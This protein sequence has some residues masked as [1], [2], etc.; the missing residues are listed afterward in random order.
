MSLFDDLRELGETAEVHR[1]AG[2]VSSGGHHNPVFHGAETIDCI[3]RPWQSDVGTQADEGYTGQTPG[4]KVFVDPDL[5][6]GRGDRLVYR[7]GDLR[8]SNPHYDQTHGLERWDGRTDERRLRLASDIADGVE[9]TPPD[10]GEGD[11]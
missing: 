9:I 4:F 8:L 5:N 2:H 6:L 1:L 7:N 3:I 10:R 11:L